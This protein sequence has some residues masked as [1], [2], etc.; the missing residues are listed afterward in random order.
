[1]PRS[2]PPCANEYVAG[3]YQL[4]SVPKI[5][6][7]TIAS[8][9]TF[10]GPIPTS[11]TSFSWLAGLEFI[12]EP[13]KLPIEKVDESGGNVTQETKGLWNERPIFKKMDDAVEIVNWMRGAL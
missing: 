1:M 13:G 9:L 6:S 3:S 7:D 8:A 11:E 2:K 10:Y 5:R 12:H 4:S